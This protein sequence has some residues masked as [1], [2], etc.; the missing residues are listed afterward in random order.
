MCI[1]D[2]IDPASFEVTFHDD[3]WAALN[4]PTLSLQREVPSTNAD[5]ISLD[6]AFTR[7]SKTPVSGMGQLATVGFIVIEDDLEGIRLPN[8]QI[9][10][11]IEIGESYSI[12]QDGQYYEY[13]GISISVPV[14]FD[15][16]TSVETL[17]ASTLS[18]Y[19]CLLY[20]SP[21]PRDATLSRMPSS[22]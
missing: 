13:E 18:L 5:Q 10:F 1:R 11:N 21:S 4:S 22:A 17:P 19:P 12:D 7:T 9:D 14:S 3:S 20:T 8:S 16:T 15:Q 2:R 6:L